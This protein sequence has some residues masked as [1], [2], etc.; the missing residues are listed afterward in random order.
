M[1]VV[2]DLIH[3]LEKEFSLALRLVCY[4]KRQ[5]NQTSTPS[6]HVKL[7][8]LTIVVYCAATLFASAQDYK[9]PTAA[10]KAYCRIYE[11]NDSAAL[12]VYAEGGVIRF[13][14]EKSR[15]SKALPLGMYKTLIL[16]M[17][18]GAK[19]KGERVVFSLEPEVTQ[20]GDVY[21]WRG[22]RTTYPD[23]TISRYI[24]DIRKND[25]GSFQVDR[26]V[27]LTAQ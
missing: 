22:I 1:G 3:V 4:L 21:S 24:V 26:E 19:A 9:T 8:S 20:T 7:S 25:N 23:K 5:E 16:S 18:S 11:Q 10:Y 27:L 6:Q 15:K 13:L 14:D 12:T 17:I 2:L